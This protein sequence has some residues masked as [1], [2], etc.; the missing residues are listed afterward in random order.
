MAEVGN[1]FVTIGSKL[2]SKGFKDATAQIKKVALAATA[3]GA[4][5]AVVGLKV[6][7][8]AGIQERAELTLAQA[9][10]QAGT[11]TK[12]AFEH[13]KK[14]A[15]SLQLMTEYGDE[16]ILGVQKFLTNFGVAGPLLDKLTLSVLDLASAKGMDLKAAADL[17]SKSVGSSTNA[18]S[19]YGITVTGAVGSTERMQMAVDNI[20]K[21]FGGA[22][23]ANADTY[24]G[25]VKS[26]SNIWGDFQEKIGFEVIPI[27]EDLIIRARDFILEASKWIDE[28]KVLVSTV[29][30]L[31]A[32]FSGLSIVVGTLTFG[33][34]TLI[35]VVGKLMTAMAAHP[36]IAVASA[37]SI[38]TVA[39]LKYLEKS[40]NAKDS[41]LELGKSTKSLIAV[42]EGELKTLNA[43]IWGMDQEDAKRQELV[44]RA[45]LLE[46]AL[47]KNRKKLAAEEIANV[48]KVATKT[49]SW[50]EKHKKLE[51]AFIEWKAGKDTETREQW[52]AWLE[53]QNTLTIEQQEF[54]TELKELEHQ[55]YKDKIVEKMELMQEF[56]DALIGLADTYY[57][58]KAQHIDN[59]L[60]K[61]LDAE[62]QKYEDRKAW[63]N[64]NIT[65]ET[66]RNEMLDALEEGHSATTKNLQDEAARKEKE[67]KKKKKRW[68]IAEAV[69]NT[70][71]GVTKAFA[72]GGAILGPIMAALVTVKGA[73]QIALIKAQKFAAGAL[74]MGPTPA[75]FGEA[76]PELALPLNHPN[77]T[78][79]LS[80]A[81]ASVGG[82]GMGNIYVTVPP[83]TSRRV[84]DEYGKVI[85][86]AIFKKVRRSRK[87]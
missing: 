58:I 38:A 33:I 85:G 50:I 48:K 41:T 54:L 37:F 70:A 8:M 82:G 72:D 66:K 20:S 43:L 21:L 18:L 76:G 44:A 78:K 59:D 35:P 74:A 31:A 53:E 81:L 68:D 67:L 32:E 86:D 75:I 10:K 69:I 19:R 61:S 57:D 84:A 12:E 63:I 60:T 47:A 49:T 56:T 52:I 6:A 80:E 36:V 24:I 11:Y 40:Q 28:N 26:L 22:A 16:A 30:A 39:L 14:Y 17:V 27:I 3:M 73:M 64:A 46:K 9:M 34:T 29:V 62:D 45:N 13:N 77:T 83:I 25:R 65:D 5:V 71:V 1:F 55:D 2:D 15:S 42:Q 87:I 51:S 79:L 7:K 23:K 4:V